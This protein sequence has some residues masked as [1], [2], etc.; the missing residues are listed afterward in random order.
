MQLQIYSGL[1]HVSIQNIYLK[2]SGLRTGLFRKLSREFLLVKN[3]PFI[4]EQNDS[5]YEQAINT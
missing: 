2:L 4:L 5:I 1:H 3:S